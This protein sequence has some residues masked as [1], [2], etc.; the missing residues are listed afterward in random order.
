MKTFT[1]LLATLLAVFALV[2]APAQAQTSQATTANVLAM[3]DVTEYSQWVMRSSGSIASGAQT[4]T[5][6]G[7]GFKVTPRSGRTFYPLSTTSPILVD[8][9]VSAVTETVTPS[10]V[11]CTQNALQSTCTVTATF[12]NAHSGNFTIKSGTFGICEAIGDLPSAGGTVVVNAGF[13]GTTSTITSSTLAGACKSSTKNILDVRNGAFQ[14]YTSNGTNYV[15]QTVAQGQIVSN[16]APTATNNATTPI[17]Y[18]GSIPQYVFMPANVATAGASFTALTGLSWT[19]PAN[20]AVNYPFHCEL[21]FNQATAATANAFQIQTSTVAPTNGTL[22]GF[23]STAA[24]TATRLVTKAYS[25]TT[26]TSI[27][28]VTPTAASTDERV[29]LD[30]FIEQPS[31]AS[32]AAVQ[33]GIA[34][35]SGGT[36]ITTVARDGWCRLF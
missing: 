21:S 35:T 24:T 19:I 31:N 5:I 27:V 7:D 6:V 36:D 16:M 17:L 20:T 34:T 23:S 10:A 22:Y 15:A 25:A 2:A 13:G 30:G 28:S 33:I 11:T 8:Q 18:A 29:E 9:E 3:P 1:T 12:S 26:A 14:M 4:I 32:S